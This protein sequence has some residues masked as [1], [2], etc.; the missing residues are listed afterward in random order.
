VLQN[1]VRA[2]WDGLEVRIISLVDLIANK[3]ASGRMQDL[4]D[5]ER[6]QRIPKR[7]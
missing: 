7:T 6:L 1:A 5:L 4:A 3:R 2:N